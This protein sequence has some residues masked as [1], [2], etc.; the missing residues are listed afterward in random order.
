MSG[1]KIKKVFG[2]LTLLN[3]IDSELKKAKSRKKVFG[4]LQAKQEIEN[5]LE[6]LEK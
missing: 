5:R 4:L 3:E 2:L 1:S 6:K